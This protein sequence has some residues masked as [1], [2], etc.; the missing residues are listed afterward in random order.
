MITSE[1]LEDQLLSIAIARERPELEEERNLLI[2][3]SAQNKKLFIFIIIYLSRI[4][5]CIFLFYSESLTK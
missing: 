5:K 3:K 1:G 4:L 2:S